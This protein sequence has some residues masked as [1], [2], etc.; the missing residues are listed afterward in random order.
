MKKYILCLCLLIFFAC[1]AMVPKEIS[2]ECLGKI[3][4]AKVIPTSF[5]ESVKMQIKTEKAIVI[6]RSLPII[7]IGAVAFEVA[8][9]DGSKYIT[10]SGDG[11]LYLIQ[12]R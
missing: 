9:N 12:R 5:N 7:R 8:F 1:E 2:R 6:I 3:I 11:K 4:D 10:F